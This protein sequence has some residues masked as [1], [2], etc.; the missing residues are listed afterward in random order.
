MCSEWIYFDV[1]KAMVHINITVHEQFRNQLT[2]TYYVGRHIRLHSSYLLGGTIDNIA[3]TYVQAR[4]AT[5]VL[6]LYKIQYY[7]IVPGAA[8]E[9][10]LQD[11]LS[12]VLPRHICPVCEGGGFVQFLVRCFSQSEEH[13]DQLLHVVHP[14]S[15]ANIPPSCVKAYENHAGLINVGIR[16]IIFNGFNITSIH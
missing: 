12:T 11:D 3:V 9:A 13:A 4:D 1:S 10:I 16:Y 2:I 8:Q 15:T 5:H 7:N 6:R 14:P